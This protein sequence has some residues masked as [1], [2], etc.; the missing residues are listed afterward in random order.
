M[1]TNQLIDALSAI[2]G[3]ISRS[4]LFW[5]MQQNMRG[6]RFL[7]SYLY[8]VGSCAQGALAPMLHVSAARITKMIASLESKQLV[9]REDDPTD[10]RRVT[11]RLTED[12][13]DAVR[14]N[15][16]LQA[17]LHELLVYANAAASLVTTRR[18][19]LCVMPDAAEVE[20]YRNA[21]KR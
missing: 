1:E 11:V 20:A 10:K 2:F 16:A 6:E 9:V 8:E 17:K 18:G 7:L 12:G 4:R 3:G 21:C 5:D 14:P 19:A 13:A 15:A